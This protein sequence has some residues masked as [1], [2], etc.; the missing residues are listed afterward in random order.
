MYSSTTSNSKYSPKSIRLR[1]FSL[2]E[3]M[4]VLSLMSLL[5]LISSQPRKPGHRAQKDCQFVVSLL[6]SE[7]RIAQYLGV[8]TTARSSAK[9]IIVSRLTDPQTLSQK[10]HP[11][12]YRSTI[13]SSKFASLHDRPDSIY[14]GKNGVSNPGTLTIFS[15]PT[16][17]RMIQ[18]LRGARRCECNE[19][20]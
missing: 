17:C 12:P 7:Q 16:S 6:N 2:P 4:M 20:R 5:L 18:S 9:T 3:L 19:T 14:L 11:L 15:P 13:I 8:D 1:G 10:T